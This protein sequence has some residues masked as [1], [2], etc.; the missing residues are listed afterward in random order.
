MEPSPIETTHWAIK[1]QLNELKRVEILPC[2]L[3]HLCVIKLEIHNKRIIGKSKY[4]WRFH[5]TLLNNTV[6]KEVS[7]E[8]EKYFQ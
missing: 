7:R 4:N 5:H 2:M 1:T 3:S 8:I 6:V